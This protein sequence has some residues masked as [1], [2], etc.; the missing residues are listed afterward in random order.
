MKFGEISISQALNALVAHAI[1]LPGRRLK[2]GHVITQQDIGDFEAIGIDHL[3]VAQLEPGDVEENAAATEIAAALCDGELSAA[4]AFTGRVNIYAAS[5]GIF[6]ADRDLVDRLNRITPSITLACLNDGEFVEAGR[7][8]ATVKIIPFAVEE[9]LVA[10]AVGIVSEGA[11]LQLIP[12]RALKVGLIAT[13]L[14]SLKPATMDKTARILADR[15]SP[16]G[17]E[18][19]AEQRVEHAAGAVA[20]ALKDLRNQ[21]D[22]LIVFGASAITDRADVIPAGIEQSGGEVSYFGMPVDPGNLLLLGQLHGK[23]VI[24]APGC[25]RSPAENGFDWVLQRVICNL[26]VDETYLSGLGVGGLL[27][28]ISARP[29]PREG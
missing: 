9:S 5:T 23:T 3:T 20:E 16:S 21:C 2:K 4:E 10:R 13:Q 17:S 22:V 1:V 25:A 12:S 8:V 28:E 19:V 7:M 27:M 18:L 11:V 29:Q 24:G 26:P 14:P 6:R 15:L